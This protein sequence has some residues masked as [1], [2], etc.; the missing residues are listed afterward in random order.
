MYS[1]DCKSLPSVGPIAVISVDS[2][3]ALCCCM[4]GQVALCKAA[5]V[6]ACSASGHRQVQ[7]QVRSSDQL[8]R[9]ILLLLLRAFGGI[10]PVFL[11][12]FL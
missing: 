7:G 10:L 4:C 11:L 9:P 5:P 1:A 3:G 2:M 12:F 8:T 6:A